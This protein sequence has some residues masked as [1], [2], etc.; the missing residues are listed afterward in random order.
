[1]RRITTL[2]L[3]SALLAAGPAASQFVE[4]WDTDG[5][6]ALSQEEWSSALREQGVFGE[7]D[8]DGNGTVSE[9][10]FAS[11]LFG[12]FNENGDDALTQTEWDTG[13][14][15]WFGEQAVDVSWENW[16]TDGDD[17]L[18]EEEFTTAFTDTD[19]FAGFA[20]A[21]GVEDPAAGIGEEEFLGGLFDWFDEDDDDLL[22]ADE[23][24][25][26]G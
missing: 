12:R 1:M 17:S 10:E 25:W 22:I 21:A 2:L 4:E 18:T 24:G 11:G 14:D 26:F 23:G 6:G 9:E 15:Q 5:D 3:G 13:I 7:F 19:L 20:D 8:A 16:N